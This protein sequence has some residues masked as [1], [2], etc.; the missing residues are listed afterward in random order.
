MG[1]EC[2]QSMY[3]DKATVISSKNYKQK[4]SIESMMPMVMVRL[5]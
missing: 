1:P 2:L 3:A 4:K 5:F